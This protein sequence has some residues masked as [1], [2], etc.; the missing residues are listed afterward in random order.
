MS[1]LQNQQSTFNV[2][3]I[4]NQ[5]LFSHPLHAIQNYLDLSSDCKQTKHN[6][7]S[8]SKQTKHYLSSDS[9]QTKH[10]L[11]SDSKQTKHYLSSDRKQTKHYSGHIVCM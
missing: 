9:K 4:P 1:T 10:N 8:D 7:S 6:L 5:R 3:P 11:S 2:G